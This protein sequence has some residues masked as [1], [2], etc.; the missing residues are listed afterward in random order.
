MPPPPPL[1]RWGLSASVRVESLMGET[2]VVVSLDRNMPK[3]L[4]LAAVR[5]K[6]KHMNT[7]AS[8]TDGR[9]FNKICLKIQ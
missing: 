1:V 9:Y 6:Q 3:L 7:M 8:N 4:L 5:P 2:N